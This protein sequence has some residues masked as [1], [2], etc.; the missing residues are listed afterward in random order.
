MNF[1]K[2]ATAADDALQ[3][4]KTLIIKGWPAYKGDTSTCTRQYWPLCD[5][6]H[7]IEGLVFRD[8]SLVIPPSVRHEMLTNLHENH[9]DI[10][11]CKARER[12]I[13]YWPRMGRDIEE[14]K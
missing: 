1:L 13:M 7:I 5:E 10:E 14:T 11:K 4:V 6:L 12:F 8:E 9:L 3:M 2:Q